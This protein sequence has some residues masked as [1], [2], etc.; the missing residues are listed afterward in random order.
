M[1]KSFSFWL[2]FR[3]F[4]DCLSLYAPLLKNGYPSLGDFFDFFY[5]GNIESTSM[6]YVY[7]LTL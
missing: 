2:S 5:F 7:S 6:L 1:D 4:Y 3:L